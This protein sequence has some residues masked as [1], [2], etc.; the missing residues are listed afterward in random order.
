MLNE[1]LI[2]TG[3]GIHHSCSSDLCGFHAFK[4]Y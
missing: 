1:N 3:H 2:P 4:Y